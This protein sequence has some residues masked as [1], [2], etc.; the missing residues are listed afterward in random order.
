MPRWFRTFLHLTP[1]VAGTSIA[2]V[3][4]LLGV[5]ELISPAQLA[6]SS[7]A[8]GNYLQTVGG[9][10]AVLLAF[11]VYVVWGQFNDARTYVDR[12]ATALVDLHRIASGLPP[13]TRIEIQREL[14]GYVDAVLA[15]EWRA[16]AK[17]DE[18]TMERIGERLE[19]VWVAIHSC[20]PC[21]ECQNMIYGEVLSRFNDLSDVRTSRLSSS[22]AR[23][24]IAMKI[25]LYAGAFIMIGSMWL[26]SFDKLW[27]H[28]TVTAALAGAVSHILFLIRDLDDAFAGDWQVS[29]APFERARRAFDRDTHQIEANAAA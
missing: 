24:P 6:S 4:G 8:V 16:M 20:E 25:L 29:R 2:S 28:A 13:K 5:R 7:D 9:I 15:D 27:L 23:I 18:V 12:E 22:R 1:V 14:R 17:G 26:M 10:Y 11:I 21:S 19:H 3:L